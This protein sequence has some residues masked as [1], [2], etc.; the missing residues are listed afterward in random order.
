MTDAP[1]PRAITDTHAFAPYVRILGRGPGK[2]RSLTRTEARH[3]LGMVL[4]GEAT[5]EQIGAMLMLLRYRG[6]AI[7]E[8]AGLVEAA[9]DHAGLPWVSSQPVDLDWPSY[10]DGRT[11]GLPWYLLSALLIARSGM[12]VLMH[13]PMNGPGRVP[14]VV[15][16]RLLGIAPGIEGLETTGFAFAPLEALNP[17]LADLLALRGVLGLRSPLNTVGR[18]LNPADACG[19]VDGVFHPAYVAVHVGTAALLGRNVSVLKG[20]G[21]EAEW[22]GVKPL[23]VTTPAGEQT[24]PA[25]DT[26]GKPDSATPAELTQVWKRE[27][28]DPAGE[29]TVIATA[30]VAL[31]AAG[32][33]TDLAACVAQ[34]K[35]LWA[36]R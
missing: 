19:G 2:S 25:L 15:S 34:A 32:W 21:G 31:Q 16:L 35:K 14:L 5:R 27:R 18:L 4:R 30:A 1:P 33:G 11:R 36:E 23:V 26:A 17:A 10:A 20:G 28:A 7:D 6:E 13:G 12:R 3:A 22:S 24:W 9:R 8:M 29:T